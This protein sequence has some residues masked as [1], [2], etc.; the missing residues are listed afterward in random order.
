M[1][2]TFNDCAKCGDGSLADYI[3][4]MTHVLGQAGD[5]E[6]PNAGWKFL[7]A[8][9]QLGC[10]ERVNE[11]QLA[12]A[13]Y[14][15]FVRPAPRNFN[16][17]ITY[18]LENRTCAAFFSSRGHEY[19]HALAWNSS[20]MLHASPYNEA[21]NLVMAPTDWIKMQERTEQ[22]A[23]AKQAWLNW[24]G[25]RI[26]PELH[27][28]KSDPVTVADFERLRI[29]HGD[30]SSTLKHA[31]LES[32]DRK[33]YGDKLGRTLRDHY[34]RHAIQGYALV[35]RYLKRNGADIYMVKMDEDDFKTTGASFGPN[36]FEDGDKMFADQ[37]DLSPRNARYLA[38]VMK[39]F[40]L[41]ESRMP[42][43]KSTLA[44][45]DTTPHEFLACSR[46]ASISPRPGPFSTKAYDPEKR[47]YVY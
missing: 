17:S 40:G 41:D 15:P 14:W 18:Q 37:P 34:H 22:D 20:P 1:N 33:R 45:M 38:K 12:T 29:R 16:N 35:L 23:Y 7:N 44:Q 27:K 5:A 4:H 26:D 3:G 11:K 10:E 13:A 6:D 25:A 32:M 36:I 42:S 47:A 2:E 21:T 31:A 43:F 46:D 28:E 8:I 39:I 30:L 19:I 9:R 24:M